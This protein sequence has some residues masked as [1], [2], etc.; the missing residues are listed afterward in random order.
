MKFSR[1]MVL[2]E[3]F[4]QNFSSLKVFSGTMKLLWIVAAGVLMLDARAAT[5]ALPQ[6]KTTPKRVAVFK[7]GLGFVL[8]SGEAKL[9]DGMAEMDSLPTASFNTR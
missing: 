8:R 1:R 3:A 2:N 7:N 4:P 5:E 9:R 6:V